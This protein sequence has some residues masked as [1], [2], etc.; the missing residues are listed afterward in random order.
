MASLS[1]PDEGLVAGGV[2]V[3]DELPADWVALASALVELPVAVGVVELAATVGAGMVTVPARLIQ[4]PRVWP[5]LRLG[6][7]TGAAARM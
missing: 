4:K 6:F 7:E 3:L 2:I 1:A 5:T